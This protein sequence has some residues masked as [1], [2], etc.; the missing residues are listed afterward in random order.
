VS[1]PEPDKRTGGLP[2]RPCDTIARTRKVSAVARQRAYRDRLGKGE[3][4]LKVRVHHDAIIT[5]LLVSSR[6]TEAGAL[7]RH[8]VEVAVSEIVAEWA[9]RWIAVDER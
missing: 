7:D 9:R 1:A 6:L 3:A 5:A 4:I 2:S 8:R